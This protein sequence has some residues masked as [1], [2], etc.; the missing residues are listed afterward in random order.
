MGGAKLLLVHVSGLSDGFLLSL[1][2][3]SSEMALQG[4]SFL[5]K[6]ISILNLG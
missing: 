4:V 1:V 6:L 5:R 2:G 3:A